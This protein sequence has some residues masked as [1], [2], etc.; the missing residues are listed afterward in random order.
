MPV[1]STHHPR[2]DANYTPRH[3]FD[4]QVPVLCEL[5]VIFYLLASLM[6]YVAKELYP[7]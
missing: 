2:H 4:L 1:D 5:S 7:S 6:L 3:H